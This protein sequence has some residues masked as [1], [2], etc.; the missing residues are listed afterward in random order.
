MLSK[1]NIQ[2]HLKLGLSVFPVIDFEPPPDKS[3]K[4]ACA[5][6]E[7]SDQPG[8]PPSLIRVLAV[9]MKKAWVISYPVSPS[10]DSEH[11]SAQSDQSLRWAHI[12]FVGFDMRHF[13]CYS[14][15]ALL[16][17]ELTVGLWFL[18]RKLGNMWFY[19]NN[20]LLLIEVSKWENV[21][22]ARLIINTCRERK[23]LLKFCPGWNF[24]VM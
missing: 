3:N 23:M 16:C 11:T 12:H 21:Y 2:K 18:K 13:I 1:F 15:T 17:L 10:E 20:C 14:N 8:H 6:R 22:T 19:L 24:P 7:D 9:L 4:M 5:P